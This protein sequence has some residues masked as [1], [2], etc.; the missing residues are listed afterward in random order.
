MLVAMALWLGAYWMAAAI[1]T[2]FTRG[3][4]TGTSGL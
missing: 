4:T 3:A 1:G 2:V